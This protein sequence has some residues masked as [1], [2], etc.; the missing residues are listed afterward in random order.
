MGESDPVTF[1][2]SAIKTPSIAAIEQLSVDMP[3]GAEDQPQS[4]SLERCRL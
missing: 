3:K 2:L 1:Y 4:F